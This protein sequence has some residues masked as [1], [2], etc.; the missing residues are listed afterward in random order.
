MQKA[1]H[2]VHKHYDSD[3]DVEEHVHAKQNYDGVST[4]YTS[5]YCLLQKDFAQLTVG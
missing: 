3:C 2:G 1:L 5:S 4:S